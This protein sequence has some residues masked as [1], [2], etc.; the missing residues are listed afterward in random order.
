MLIDPD[1]FDKIPQ[2]VRALEKS[3]PAD[4]I[5]VNDRHFRG[6]PRTR[7]DASVIRWTLHR[8]NTL[9]CLQVGQTTC[10]VGAVPRTNSST[11]SKRLSVT[12]QHWAEDPDRVAIN[13]DNVGIRHCH[14]PI[15]RLIG[16]VRRRGREPEE[17]HTV[18]GDPTFSSS[19]L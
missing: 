7:V 12:G 14:P 5:L 17:G 18:D 6:F 8:T 15:C 11:P 4:F 10:V 16:A 19:K 3:F 1:K 9:F 2:R 13:E